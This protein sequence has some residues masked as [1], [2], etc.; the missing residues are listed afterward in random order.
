MAAQRSRVYTC[1]HRHFI[2]LIST[3]Q[4]PKLFL[5][6]LFEASHLWHR[7]IGPA[8]TAHEKLAKALPTDR[9]GASTADRMPETHSAAQ[10][11]EIK[12]SLQHPTAPTSTYPTAPPS[13]FVTPTFCTRTTT[14]N[15]PPFLPRVE[16]GGG[17][18]KF[19]RDPGTTGQFDGARYDGG[20]GWGRRRLVS[21]VWHRKVATGAC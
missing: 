7:R 17:D 14:K 2:S 11:A 4:Q 6:L 13:A 16:N 5:S 20:L 8:A 9:S 21:S 10:L 18:G 19:G 1:N 3:M 15:L 12:T